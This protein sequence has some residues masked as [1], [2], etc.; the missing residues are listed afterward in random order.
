MNMTRMLLNNTFI[1][2]ILCLFLSR[3]TNTRRFHSAEALSVP[4]KHFQ[5]STTERKRSSVATPF[6]KRHCRLGTMTPLSAAASDDESEDA[7]PQIRNIVIAGGGI[8]GTS[9]AYYLVQD[10][11][12]DLEGPFSLTL[13]DPTGKVGSC[14]SGKAGG[15]LARDWRNGTPL[16]ELQQTGFAM[17][18]QL[19]KALGSDIVDYRRLTCAAVAVDESEEDEDQDVTKRRVPN[20][21]PSKKLI[22]LEWVDPDVVLWDENFSGTPGVYPMGDEESIAQVHPRKLCEAMWESIANDS[23]A[24]LS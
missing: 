7:A 23:S 13:V 11:L 6:T 15:F 5:Q 16:Q 4:T 10:H 20:K 22:D 8:V 12:K 19:A 3:K 18:E 2:T 24:S 17:H 1:A 21:P 14:A 9:V